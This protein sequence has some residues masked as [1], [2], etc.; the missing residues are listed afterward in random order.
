[1]LEITVKNKELHDALLVLV[2]LILK[3]IANAGPKNLVANDES[4]WI[5][6]DDG[7]FAREHVRKII[8]AFATEKSIE[9]VANTK[10]YSDFVRII[11]ED[12]WISP[13]I[14]TLVGSCLSRIRLGAKHLVLWLVNEFLSNDGIKPF[15]IE[16]FNIAYLKIESELYANE[17]EF[18]KITPLCGLDIDTSEIRLSDDISIVRLDDSE[19]LDFFNLGIKLGYDLGGREFIY[20]ANECAI[21]MRFKLPKIIGEQ[22]AEIP[23]NDYFTNKN[24]QA[25]IDALRVHKDGNIYPIATL[26][27]SKSR[28]SGAGQYSFEAP[29]KP[30]MNST[31]KLQAEEVGRFSL[32]WVERNKAHSIST[33]IRRF[34]QSAAR[35]NDEDRMIDLMIA[36]EAIFLNDGNGEMAY[37]LAHR[38]SVFL[39]SDLSG[40]KEIFDF[41]KKAYDSRSKIVHGDK[42]KLPSGASTLAEACNTLEGYLRKA[43][44]KIIMEHHSKKIEWDAIVFP[45]V[46]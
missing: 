44:Q 10:E 23:N 15:D 13:Q 14:D 33:G 28:L 3:N 9:E 40:Q 45:S 18:E 41:M 4:V 43:I 39:S 16:K 11:S 42:P 12:K 24:E 34:S 19:I 38:A 6:R 26:T 20:T 32:I 37:K 1:M 21:K 30:F 35:D 36:A 7:I 31:Y 8:W 27:K 5:K 25:V 29:V 22:Q 2:Q 46:G 17:I